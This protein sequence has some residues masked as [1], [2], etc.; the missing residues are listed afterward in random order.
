M[1]LFYPTVFPLRQHEFWF[2]ANPNCA[3]SDR[4]SGLE[5][6]FLAHCWLQELK[7]D[8]LRK[9]VLRDLIRSDITLEFFRV[10]DATLVRRIED[11]LISGRLHLHKKEREVQSG[12]GN[13][14]QQ[15][16]FPLSQHQPREAYVPPPVIDAPSFSRDVDLAAQAATLVAAAAQGTPFCPE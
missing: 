10:S 14:D 9:S 2:C 1:A 7:S 11:L 16:P 5:G 6:Q 8:Q 3:G 15:V 13:Q 4:V 12:S